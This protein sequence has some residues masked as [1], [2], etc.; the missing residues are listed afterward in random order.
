MNKIAL[1][2]V[3]TLLLG[4]IKAQDV[5]LTNKEGS[6]YKFEKIVHLEATPVESQGWTGTCWSYSALSFFESE[7][8]RRGKGKDN[9]LSEMYIV[10]QAYLGKADKYMRTDGNTNF[11]EGGAFHDIPWVIERFGI[12][13]TEAYKGLNYGSETHTHSELASVLKGA[14]DGLIKRRRKL[15]NGAHLTTAWKPALRGILNAYLG[16]IPENIEDFTFKVK[17]KE[18]NPITYRDE[19]GLN[20]ND[21]ISLTSFS[22][23]PYYQ[24]CQLAIADNW[25]WG[26]SYNVPLDDLWDAATYALKEGFSFA[27][28]SDVSEKYFNFRFKKIIQ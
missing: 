9:I 3:T 6:E 15:K 16:E 24:T 11:D 1:I 2:L 12:V 25:V 17:G 14:M 19:M 8:D 4:N 28:G 27:W 7:L 13:P 5:C 20:M 21:Y 23:H 26:S 10:Y 18:Y 22:N